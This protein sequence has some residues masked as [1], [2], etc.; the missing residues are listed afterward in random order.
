MMN[1]IEYRKA[2]LEFRR[3]GSNVLTTNYEE[4]NLH[5]IRLR[6]YIEKNEII[7]EIISDKIKDVEDS[8]KENL[9]VS[10]GG[11]SYLNVSPNEDE[12]IKVVYYYLIDI[13]KERK[14]IRGIARCFHCSSTSW[15]DIIRNYMNKVFK[16]LIDFVI[17]SLSKEMMILESEKT[18]THITQN[19]SSNY[20]TANIAQGDIHSI[21]TIDQ[22]NIKEITDL[23]TEVRG[24]IEGSEL[25]PETKEEV[26][27]DLETAKEQ[28]ES[29]QPKIIKLKKAFNGLKNFVVSIPNGIAHAT[30][31]MTKINNL[32]EK[33]QNFMDVAK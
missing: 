18:V 20:G 12:H 5:L 13:T 11:W 4:G 9:I 24:L 8:Y 16:P 14:D 25:S 2:S 7:H 3:L 17:D 30:L 23:I 31:I 22:N 10:D 1:I 15:N 26:V 28:I 27:D 32:T 33:I 21:N 29:K 6:M 19:I